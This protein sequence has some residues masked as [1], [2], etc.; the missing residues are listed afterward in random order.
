MT[1]WSADSD[2]AWF[3]AC[4]SSNVPLWCLYRWLK[5][6]LKLNCTRIQQILKIPWMLQA[7]CMLQYGANCS[8]STSNSSQE[9][10]RI[11]NQAIE[12]LLVWRFARKI[13]EKSLKN[14]GSRS[15]KWVLIP[16]N[17]YD[18]LYICLANY[19]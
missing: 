17:S 13:W 4:D 1:S 3:K 9:H 12:E 2:L 10:F 15:E 8:N 6:K 16:E 5:E 19:V 18:F 14:F 11:M 7:L